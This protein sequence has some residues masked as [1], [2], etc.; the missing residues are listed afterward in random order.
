MN[1]NLNSN[2]DMKEFY[3]LPEEKIAKFPPVNRGDARL[4]VLDRSKGTIQHYKY[5]DLVQFINPDELVILNNTKVFKARL[6][7]FKINHETNEK[8][9]IELLLLEKHGDQNSFVKALYKGK[10]KSGD[11]LFINDLEI[12]VVDIIKGGIAL[13]QTDIDL[14]EYAENHGE[15]PIP[16][17]LK[18]GETEIDKI[19]YQTVFAKET[20]SAAAPTASLNFTDEIKNKLI[21]NGV[22]IDY[23]TLHVGLGTFMPVRVEDLNNHKMHSEYYKISS[24]TLQNIR[25]H[26]DNIVAVGTTVARA[27]EHA[28][29]QI[30]SDVMEIEDEANI[31][32]HP[33]YKFK[34]VNKLLTNFHAPD[35]TVILLAA[36]FAGE[37]LL[38]EA[39]NIA[40]KEDY[41]FLSYGDSMLII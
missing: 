21:T 41:K 10:L 39:Y 24:S 31:F 29:S 6:K 16:P 9:E 2:F 8:K 30:N 26:S 15:I 5:E 1:P 7:T 22:D 27:L 28:H 18:R 35:S 32:I 33:G 19:R 20:G 37:E 14:Y 3:K 36:A 17:Y 38:K 12:L 11:K 13:I 40:I 4:M 23:L 25:S 34:I